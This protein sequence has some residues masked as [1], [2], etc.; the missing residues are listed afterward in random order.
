MPD[1]SEAIFKPQVALDLEVT[2]IQPVTF[3]VYSPDNKA[4]VWDIPIS[5]QNW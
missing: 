1:I 4:R 2:Q 3:L 5:A